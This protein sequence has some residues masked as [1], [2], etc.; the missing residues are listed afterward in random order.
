MRKEHLMY[1]GIVISMLVLLVYG[2]TPA[3]KIPMDKVYYHSENEGTSRC[4]FVFLPG[5][6]AKT[7]AFESFGFI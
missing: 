2:C 7:E 1:K 4:L 6:G 3:T 5:K